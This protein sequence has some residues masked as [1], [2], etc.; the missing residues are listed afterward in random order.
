METH[1]KLKTFL[2]LPKCFWQTYSEISLYGSY[3]LVDALNNMYGMVRFSE[4][5]N[6]YIPFYLAK[7]K[8][9][10]YRSYYTYGKYLALSKESDF[11]LARFSVELRIAEIYFPRFKD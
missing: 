11:D 9:K 6:N 5:E 1:S 4:T 10:Y 2:K 8:E 3:Y 7:K